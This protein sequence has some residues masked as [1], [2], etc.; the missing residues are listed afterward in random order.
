MFKIAVLVSGGGTNLQAIINA[1]A[2]NKLEDCIIDVVISSNSNAYALERA[3]ENNI[4][5]FIISKKDFA[6]PSDEILKILNDRRIDLIVLAGY[7]SI[8]KGNILKKYK[9][10]IINIHPSLIPAFCGKDMY[11]I[12]VHESVIESGVK[13][14]GCTVHY[15]NE[16]VDEGAIILQTPITVED[17]DTP[18]LLQKRLLKY[19]HESLI[20]AIELISKNKLQVTKNKTRLIKE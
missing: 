10:K 11:G 19:E 1:I 6:N 18:E 8:L 2:N 13:I 12:K 5:T 14:T 15:V 7:L 16:G 20:K 3:K 4:D 17:N 9:N